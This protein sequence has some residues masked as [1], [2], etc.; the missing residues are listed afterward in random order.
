MLLGHVEAYDGTI[1]LPTF[2]RKK[3]ELKLAH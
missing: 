3:I 1:K 2:K